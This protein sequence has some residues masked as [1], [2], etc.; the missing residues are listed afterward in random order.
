MDIKRG[1]L[2]KRKKEEALAGRNYKEVRADSKSDFP[3]DF[4][5]TGS[6]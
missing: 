6:L 3:D 5:K 4:R 2:M 1:F